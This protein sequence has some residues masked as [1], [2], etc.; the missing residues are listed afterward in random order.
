ME[1]DHLGVDAEVLES[2]F[3][4]LRSA[5]ERRKGAPVDRD[6][7][8]Y[9]EVAA[10][11]GR[12]GRVHGEQV[13]DG[14]EGELGAVDLAEEL[15]VGEERRVPGVVEG[16]AAR[17]LDDVAGGETAVEDLVAVGDAARVV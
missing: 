16:E 13:A 5:L 3:E 7:L 9:A 4:L 14:Q 12:R 2:L 10:G 1:G 17:K 11:A 8:A 6:H 15:H